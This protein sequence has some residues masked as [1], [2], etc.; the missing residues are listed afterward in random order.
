MTLRVTL[1]MECHYACIVML[2]VIMLGVL[3]LNVIRVNVMAPQKG[4]NSGI[5]CCFKF[6]LRFIYMG[7]VTHNV[8]EQKHKHP[9][10][11]AWP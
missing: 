1:Y 2:D 10:N 8:A 4:S 7:N 3:M 5:L 9:K 6:R 11:W